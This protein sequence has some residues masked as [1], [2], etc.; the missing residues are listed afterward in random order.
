IILDVNLPLENGL[1]VWELLSDDRLLAPIPVVMLTGSSDEDTISRCEEL[2]AHYVLKSPDMWNCLEPI[3]CELLESVPAGA[4]GGEPVA[5]PLA[6]P[7]ASESA[8]PT[9]LCIDDDRQFCKA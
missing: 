1:N 2:G 9:V 3:I 5:A 4:E 8:S 7:L 6:D